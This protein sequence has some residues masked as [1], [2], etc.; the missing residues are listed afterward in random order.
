MSDTIAEIRVPTPELRD[1]LA[2]YTK[3]LGKRLDTIYPVDDAQ[4]AVSSGH[5]LRLRIENG[6][7]EPQRTIRILTDDPKGFDKGARELTAQNG[8]RLE[9][10]ERNPP[11]VMPTTLHS[12]VVR[13][14]QG[15][16][17]W[18]R[19]EADILF[20][21]VMEG[22]VALQGVERDPYDLTVGDAFV[23]PPGMNARLAN[24]S[25]V[26]E[27]HEVALPGAVR[28]EMETE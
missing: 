25:D 11:V 17:V 7:T 18:A 9:I 12:F 28:T 8:T 27:L 3:S 24:P 4:V 26:I 22:S 14:G 15:D 19:H 5:G 6:A 21:F 1:D 23:I 2:F 20:T 16:P 10:A 13:R